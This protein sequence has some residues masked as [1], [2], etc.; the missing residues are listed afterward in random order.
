M[1]ETMTFC[2]YGIDDEAMDAST[3]V[4]DVD[5]LLL[6]EEID[7]LLEAAVKEP[8]SLMM[9]LGSYHFSPIEAAELSPPTKKRRVRG[10]LS[11]SSAL[12]LRKKVEI[13]TLREEAKKLEGYLAQLRRT[14]G[15]P[16]HCTLAS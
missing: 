6:L 2:D 15:L 1:D 16:N 14:N 12:R 7:D 11:T 10:G 8:R 3:K 9:P 13:E 4:H 5:D